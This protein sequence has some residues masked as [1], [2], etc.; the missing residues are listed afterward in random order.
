MENNAVRRWLAW[1][2]QSILARKDDSMAKKKVA[3]PLVAV[4]AEAGVQQIYG[5]AGDSLNGITRTD[6]SKGT[7]PWIHRDMKR[8]RSQKI[9][10]RYLLGTVMGMLLVLG[11]TA[12]RTQA[13]ATAGTDPDLRFLDG[14]IAHHQGAIDEARAIEPK[15]RRPEVKQLA[16][17][18]IKAQ[19]AEI[20]QMR[21]WRLAWFPN[22]PQAAPPSGGRMAMGGGTM[23]GMPHRGM[24]MGGT[25][26]G[27]APAD[28]DLAFIEMMIPHHQDAVAMSR[29]ILDTT[30]RPEL[31]QLARNIIRNQEREIAQ[32]ESWKRSWGAGSK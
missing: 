5:V 23:G 24:P 30:K 29:E 20:R 28:P 7:P 21:E 31:Q 25:P 1:R 18:I 13:Q 16:A 14:M 2:S 27:A 32:M 11:A 19:E 10:M 9:R 17:E 15:A 22:T 12:A 4:L 6:S 26:A 8:G 3:D